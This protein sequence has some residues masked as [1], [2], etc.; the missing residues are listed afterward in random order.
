MKERSTARKTKLPKGRRPVGQAR[1]GIP[2]RRVHHIERQEASKAV[3]W[4]I[5]SIVVVAI[6]AVGYLIRIRLSGNDT[7]TGA[8]YVSPEERES[9][10]QE[11]EEKNRRAEQERRDQSLRDY[12]DRAAEQAVK[13]DDL[14]RARERYEQQAEQQLEQERRRYAEKQSE[15]R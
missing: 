1:R 13:G 8:P 3:V 15:N 6:A 2:S 11:R 4:I 5:T 12:A 7:T 10:R 14:D 9:F